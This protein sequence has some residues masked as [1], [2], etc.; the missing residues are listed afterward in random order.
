MS[1]ECCGI[2]G[3]S[4]SL[5]KRFWQS[6]TTL[7]PGIQNQNFFPASGEVG[8]T[9]NGDWKE[10][11]DEFN[12]S[13]W[14]ASERAMQFNLGW[15]GNPVFGTGDYPNVM[16][17]MIDSKTIS[18]SSEISRLPVLSEKDIINLKGDK[19]YFLISYL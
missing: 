3:W 9:L 1:N 17:D 10:P 16:R 15:C 6:K 2:L 5:R 7:K 19:L 12:P 4:N 13:D 11:S 14:A 18:T 8:I